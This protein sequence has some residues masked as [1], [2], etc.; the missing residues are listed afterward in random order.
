MHLRTQGVGAMGLAVALA[1]GIAATPQT[2]GAHPGADAPVGHVYVNDN[3]AGTNTVAGFA[4]HAEGALTPLAG[5]PFSIGGAGTGA[6]IG[7]RAPF[8]SRATAATF[9]PSMRAAVRS[10]VSRIRGTG[11]WPG[12][13]EARV[14]PRPRACQSRRARPPHLCC[15]PRE[16]RDRNQLHRLP[17]QPWGRLVHL[18]GST[19]PLPV[20]ASPGDILFN[21]TGKQSHRDRGRHDRPEHVPHRQL[22]RGSIRASARGA[23]SPFPAQARV[24][25]GASSPRPIRATSTCPMR[26]EV[27][28]P[29]PCRPSTWGAAAG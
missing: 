27:P 23:G 8:R 14:V 19:I 17:T 4:E 25:S 9:W 3:T 10:L 29:G 2:A 11:R 28:T 12:L 18:S 24:R 22:R 26:T 1:A 7:S 6:T 16:R 20:T 13:P 15:E 21:S 5:S